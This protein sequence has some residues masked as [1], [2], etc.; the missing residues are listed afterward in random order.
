[1]LGLVDQCYG[2]Y[3]SIGSVEPIDS[4]SVGFEWPVVKN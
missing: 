2:V 1:M 4:R 3:V